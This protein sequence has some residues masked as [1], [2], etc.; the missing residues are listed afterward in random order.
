MLKTKKMI[1]QRCAKMLYIFHIGNEVIDMYKTCIPSSGNFTIPL[2]HLY[3]MRRYL[4]QD[5][6]L[7]LVSWN[8]LLHV[9]GLIQCFNQCNLQQW[10][11]VW[12]A[13][14]KSDFKLWDSSEIEKE[15]RLLFCKRHAPCR[16]KLW[17]FPLILDIK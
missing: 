5:A 1:F 16:A 13:S 9:K 11:E 10:S 15:T 3:L 8:L 6:T 2:E 7:I 17:R 14:V 4:V 12:G